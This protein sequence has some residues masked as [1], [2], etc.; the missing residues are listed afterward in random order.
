MWNPHPPLSGFPFVLVFLLTA[1][2]LRALFLKGDDLKVWN[3]RT[4]GVLLSFSLVMIPLTY[5]SG[6]FGADFANARFEVP[7]ELILQHQLWGKSAL[8]L[9]IGCGVAFALYSAAPQ[10]KAGARKGLR[11]LYRIGIFS[12][13]ALLARASYLGGQ[14]VFEHG[15]GVRAPIASPTSNTPP[16]PP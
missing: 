4:V 12:L 9:M 6:Y 11:L 2:E 10:H 5:F 16:T 3:D 1:L 15:A 8:F 7:E 14:L 13:V